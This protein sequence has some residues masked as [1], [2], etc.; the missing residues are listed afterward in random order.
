M[1]NKVS[2][3]F[4]V[5]V[6]G[7]G[8]SGVTAAISA[9]RLG[10]SVLLIEKHGFF[11]GMNTAGLVGP[12]M[13]FHAGELQIV[14]GI[15]EELIA[16]LKSRNGTPGHLVDP[17]WANTSMTPVDTELYKSVLCE[18]IERAGVTCL[19]HTMVTE[20]RREGSHLKELIISNKRGNTSVKAKFY[21][22]A[23]GDGDL[24]ASAGCGFL[25]GRAKD[26]LTQPMSLMFKMAGVNEARIRD[27]IRDNPKEFYLG[28][29]LEKFLALPA[30]AVSGFFSI[31]KSAREMGAFPFDRDRVLFFGLPRPGE[32]T[33]NTLRINQVSG[34][35]PEDL[36][37]AEIT[38]RKQVPILSNFMREFIPGFEN[39][40]VTETAPQVG[41]R[42]T[43]HIY[44]D[45]ILTAQD[46]FAQRKFEDVVAHASYPIDVHSPDG[47]GMEIKD[48]RKDNPNSFYDI[49]L[50][51]LLPLGI[52]NLLITGR[53]ISAEHEASASARISATCMALGEACGVVVSDVVK[54]GQ[55]SLREVNIKRVQ[56]Q[57]KKQGAFLESQSR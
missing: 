50:R 18:V 42:E 56:V 46:I 43:R 5:V 57:L 36:T 24:A 23:T 4:D 45:Y 41:V 52:E 32:V 51:S 10:L 39:A 38:L 9:A 48:P 16:N 15:A 26:N 54:H 53:C 6:A 14:R 27:Y 22:D 3:Q 21:I 44:G 30:L 8:P 55:E 11:G 33:V 40:F 17:I 2:Q 35:V 31:V 29:T 19:L 34:V 37:R 12:I 25:H 1:T 47:K 49:P 7:G 13:T 20:T 28:F